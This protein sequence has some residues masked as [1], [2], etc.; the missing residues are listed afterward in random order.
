MLG[1]PYTSEKLKMLLKKVDEDNNG[2]L[3]IDEYAELLEYL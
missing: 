3:N 1:K 2:K